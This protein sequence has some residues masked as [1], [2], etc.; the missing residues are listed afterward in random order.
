[1]K[2]LLFSLVCIFFLVGSVW[3]Q[4]A[5]DA[6]ELTRLLNEFLD[7]AGRNDAAVHDRFWAEDLIYTRGAGQRVGKA[8]IMSSVRSS[9]P[10]KPGDPKTVY[11]AEDVKIQQYGQTAVVAFRLVGRTESGGRVTVSNNLNTGTFVKR[12][13]KWQVVA[14][15]STRMPATEDENRRHVAAVEAEFHRAILESDTNK[16]DSVLHPSFVW[17]HRTGRSETK[18]Q[19]LEEVGSGKLK[20]AKL[21]TKDVTINMYGDSAVARGASP[22]QR[23]PES[24]ANNASKPEPFTL[25]YTLTFVNFNGTWRIVAAHSSR[26]EH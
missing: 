26:P 8:E 18:Q 1:M 24:A 12:K 13:G 14:W 5:S 16:L 9:P 3:A 17:I 15:Q 4:S 19:L 25:Y 7:G 2:N 21:E 23:T 11:S 22:R 6:A 10:A 20:Y